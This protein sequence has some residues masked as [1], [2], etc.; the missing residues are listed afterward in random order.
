MTQNKRQCIDLI[1]LTDEINDFLSENCDYELLDDNGEIIDNGEYMIRQNYFDGGYWL[2]K[3]TGCYG[4]IIT[5][6]EECV[7][8][9]DE[10]IEPF[11]KML[12]VAIKERERSKIRD[13]L[14]YDKIAEKKKTKRRM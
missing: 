14:N 9:K 12:Q 8:L 7:N 2:D 1:Y 10:T 13:G 3:R 11:Y 4:F 6:I 5:S